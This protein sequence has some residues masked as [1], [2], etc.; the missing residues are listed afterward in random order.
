MKA[1]NRLTK[2]IALLLVARI[3]FHAKTEIVFPIIGDVT[4]HLIVKTG[5]TKSRMTAQNTTVSM[6]RN[7]DATARESKL[8]FAFA[9][10]ANCS[11]SCTI[12]RGRIKG[13]I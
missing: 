8:T 11:K 6:I 4:A 10:S 5:R 2:V 12:F 9:N 1:V 7:L 13:R 3:N